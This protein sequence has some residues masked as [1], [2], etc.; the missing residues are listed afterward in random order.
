[1][2]PSLDLLQQTKHSIQALGLQ[3]PQLTVFPTPPRFQLKMALSHQPD[4]RLTT[5]GSASVGKNEIKGKREQGVGKKREGGK[6]KRGKKKNTPE[7]SLRCRSGRLDGS[8]MGSNPTPQGALQRLENSGAY[9]CVKENPSRA[10]VRK[11]W[12][13]KWAWLRHITE[14]LRLFYHPTTG[15]SSTKF[16]VQ[17]LSRQ[18]LRFRILPCT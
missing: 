9:A 14:R 10:H 7:A 15:G 13:V 18:T 5:P 17:R 11:D 8:L 3:I 4:P 1:M 6:G 2:P 16:V 12:R